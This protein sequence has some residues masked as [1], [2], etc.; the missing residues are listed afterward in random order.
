MSLQFILPSQLFCP[1][2]CSLAMRSAAASS[3]ASGKSQAINFVELLAKMEADRIEWVVTDSRRPIDPPGT[4]RVFLACKDTTGN[5]M[6]TLGD[7]TLPVAQNPVVAN[8][9]GPSKKNPTSKVYNAFFKISGREAEA[10]AKCMNWMVEKAYRNNVFGPG[11]ANADKLRE[12]M[13]FPFTVADGSGKSDDGVWVS[14]QMEAPKGIESLRTRFMVSMADTVTAADGST[15]TVPKILRQYD[16]SRIVRD[17][18][19]CCLFEL[20]EFKEYG[21]LFRGN[22]LGRVVLID[23]SVA[24]A[25]DAP[26]PAAFSRAKTGFAFPYNGGYI[27]FGTSEFPLP[28]FREAADVDISGYKTY[29]D[30][31]TFRDLFKSG[32]AAMANVDIGGTIR[33]FCNVEGFRGNPLICEGNLA[34]PDDMQPFLMK[35]PAAHPDSVDSKSVGALTAITDPEHAAAYTAVAEMKLQQVFDMKIVG[36]GKRFDTIDKIRGEV[37]LPGT[38]PENDG[39]HYFIWQKFNM[40][41]PKDIAELQTQFYL[42]SAPGE[43]WTCEKIDGSE[44]TAGRRFMAGYEVSEFKRATGKWR[45]V[46]YTKVV[47]VTPNLGSKAPTAIM[48]GNQ[49]VDLE[50]GDEDANLPSKR[51]RTEDST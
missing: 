43:P 4:K 37:A 50:A 49:S 3:S 28:V 27:L 18:P 7:P 47:F 17:Q 34:A 11:F 41:A 5:I 48:W 30:I 22:A 2:S 36:T 12:A 6:M 32:K 35:T 26:M 46:L 25:D 44:L 39:E 31:V 23:E 42:L 51:A 38:E 33:H 14:W 19:A 9:P 29:I 8:Q 45:E 13:S 15:T 1:S 21:G 40:E 24:L 10:M 16:G 20:G